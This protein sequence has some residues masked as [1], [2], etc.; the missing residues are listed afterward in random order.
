MLRAYA[1][2]QRQAGTTFSQRYIEN[3][4]AAHPAIARKLMELFA[5]RFDPAL[6]DRLGG[7]GAR[8]GRRAPPRPRRGGEPRR[9][10]H[11]ARLP[12]PHRGDVADE[13]LPARSRRAPSAVAQLQARPGQGPRPAAAQADVRDLGVLAARRGRA[14]ARRT[15]RPRRPALVGPHGGLPHRGARPDEGPDGEERGD[16]ARGRQGRLRGEATAGRPGRAPGRGQGEL[17]DLRAGDARHHRQHRRRRGG[18]PAAGRAPRRRRP[19]PRGGGR[20]GD[21]DLQRHGQRPRCGVRLL[22]GRRLRLRRVVGLRPQGHGHHGPRGLGERPSP[23]LR[24]RCR[25][26]HRADHRGRASATCRA[27]CSA[28]ACCS[29]EP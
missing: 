11:P 26:R 25:R 2:Y 12:D 10:P 23:L 7:G 15:S 21:R 9:G 1:K 17:L 16:R 20:Q 28:T 5:L 3:T 4:L 29:A 13:R 27:T 8:P 14:P 24:A 22:A 19:V 6:A 18:A